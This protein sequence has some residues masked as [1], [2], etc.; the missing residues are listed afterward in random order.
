MSIVEYLEKMKNVQ[1]NIL[2]F[3]ND[4]TFDDKFDQLVSLL[5]D[6]NEPNKQEFKLILHIILSIANNHHRNSTFFSR[7]SKILL[8]LKD[9]ISQNFSNLEIFNFFKSNKRILLFLLENEVIKN[10]SNI[11]NYCIY[12]SSS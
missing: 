4:D 1:I 7:I 2:D 5:S 8:F 10:D 6:Q 3:I 12:S 11:F 9:K